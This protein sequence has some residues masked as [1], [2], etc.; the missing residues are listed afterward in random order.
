MVRM[1]SIGFATQA[2]TYACAPITAVVANHDIA[3]SLR[4]EHQP[5]RGEPSDYIAEL[6]ALLRES[7]R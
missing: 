5:P 1:L 4:N 6:H 2:L 7:T 3:R